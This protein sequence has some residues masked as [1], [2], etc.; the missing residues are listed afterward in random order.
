MAFALNRANS[1]YLSVFAVFVLGIWVI[2]DLGSAFLTA[3]RDL[4]GAWKLQAG[5][6]NSAATFQSPT[7]F[8][9]AQSG[10]YL[11]FNFD[12]GPS[13]DV[14]LA[15]SIEDGQRTLRFKGEGWDIT[16]YCPSVGDTVKFSF[17]PPPDH[18]S[19]VPGTYQRQRI[20]QEN[21]P[22]VQ[23]NAQ[24]GPAAPPNAPH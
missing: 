21:P 18:P 2:L 17:Q 9:I 22:P 10:R 7:A 4:G 3:P 5:P 20:G 13:C 8:S 15:E 19:P 24:N 12:R 23:S 16:G 11:R 1:V 14:I 6:A